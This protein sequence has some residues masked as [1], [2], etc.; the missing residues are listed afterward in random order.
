[1]RRLGQ[2]FLQKI[3]AT[4]TMINALKIGASEIIIEIGPGLGA[5][6]VPLQKECLKKGCTLI[7]I[8]RD[9]IL[10]DQLAAKHPALRVIQGDA[11]KIIP[12]ILENNQESDFLNSQSSSPKIK[13]IGNI[14]YYITGSILRI[15]S[16]L[17]PR[18][19]KTVIMIQK[20]VAER[21]VAEPPQMNLL[22]A[23]TQH[24]ATVQILETLSP[25][26]FSPPPKVSS[27]IISLQAKPRTPLE[28]DQNYYR[29]IK[30]TFRQP[31]KTVLNNLKSAFGAENEEKLKKILKTQ[32]LSG[33]E[34]PQNLN[35]EILTALSTCVAH[36][37]II[38]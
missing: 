13:I 3:S 33:L 2:H 30:I 7:T 28:A 24:W 12:Q 10:A 29:L 35:L 25:E 21:I 18:P 11:V 23:A 20:E 32:G 1:M 27:A 17:N 14:P 4:E 15:L 38:E 16:N 8:E 31:R 34:R 5:L 36:M 6:T 9:S 19:E 26:D 22:A 37:R